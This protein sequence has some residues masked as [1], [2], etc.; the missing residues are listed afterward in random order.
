MQHPGDLDG[1]APLPVPT[2]DPFERI[3]TLARLATEA[4][5]PVE[6]YTARLRR[7]EQV[8]GRDNP[9]EIIAFQFRKQP[10][11][12]HF[13]WIGTEGHG[14]EVIYVKGH[15]QDQLH[16]LLGDNDMGRMLFPKISLPLDDPKIRAHSRHNITEAGLG[17]LIGRFSTLVATEA[18]PGGGVKYLGMVQRPEYPGKVEG[19]EQIVG[20]D[21]DPLM[22]GGG[23]RLWYFDPGNHFPVLIVTLDA[24]GHEVEYYCYDRLFINI[25]LDDDDFNP[26]KLGTRP[27]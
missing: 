22:P 19:V 26:D 20:R 11:S 16:T 5:A 15:Y 6:T 2:V 18:K 10:W 13:K 25:H 12:V 8:N 7:R 1:R 21:T 3:Q 14:R 17:S 4:I 24:T 23:R 27:H 9:E